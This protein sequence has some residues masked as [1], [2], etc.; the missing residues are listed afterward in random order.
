MLKVVKK[1]QSN[2]D[3][4][5]DNLANTSEKYKH[6]KVTDG[7]YTYYIDGEHRIQK[8]ETQTYTAKIENSEGS[9][10]TPSSVSFGLSSSSM[11]M[12]P[13]TFSTDV[14][15][16][17]ELEKATLTALIDGK[18]VEFEIEVVSF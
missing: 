3:D 6:T 14:T 1:G 2:S 13:S 17:E 18:V 5:D 7:Q 16:G 4:M 9:N 8:N 10:P 12:S 15:S 11:S